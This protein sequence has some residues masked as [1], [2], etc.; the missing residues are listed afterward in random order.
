MLNQPP[1][2]FIWLGNLPCWAGKALLF[3]SKNNSNQ[4]I[5]FLTD[6][7]DYPSLGRMVEIVEVSKEYISE[8]DAELPKLEFQG[9][10]WKLCSM[11]FF[12]LEKFC[13]TRSISSFFHPEL[14]NALFC[15]SGLSNILDLHGT[16][17]FVPRDSSSRAIASLIYCNRT[18]SLTELIDIY[19][20]PTPPLHDMDALDL[21][22]KNFTHFFHSLPTESFDENKANWEILSPIE[23]GGIFDAA[24]IGQYILG[25][26]PIHCQFKPCWNGFVN[27]NCNI[28]L[29]SVNFLVEDSQIFIQYKASGIKFQIYNIHLH[30]KNWKSFHK[31]M[32]NGDVLKKLNN[33]DKSIIS[34]H[35]MILVGPMSSVIYRFLAF[36]WRMYKCI[37]REIF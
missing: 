29:N 25:V 31:I 33:G 6:S 34:N 22:D 1:I 18:Q 20:S 32:S 15:L 35:L 37:I 24:A 21:Y 3:A 2:I 4:K 9:I 7:T 12:V 13:N 11:R 28:D 27:E 36:L 26:D 30:S 16:G 5:I 19:R 10:F 8:I 14:D 23:T 17:L